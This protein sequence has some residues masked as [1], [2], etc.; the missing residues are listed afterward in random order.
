MEESI[1]LIELIREEFVCETIDIR[2]YS[3]LTLAFVGDGIYDLLIRTVMAQ[4][5]NRRVEDYHKQ[6]SGLVKAQ[7]QAAM[8]EAVFA[9]LTE[10][11]AGIYRRGRNAV[12][13]S[14]AKNAS[15]ADYR[16]ATGFEAL[17]GYL[18]LAGRTKRLLQLV[19]LAL[20]RLKLGI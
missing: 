6:K 3:P 7:T 20:E 2:T 10:E 14:S 1:N 11:E 12:T 16:K 15:I 18:Y 8:A 17:C 5:G 19:R 13:H 9:D 4:R